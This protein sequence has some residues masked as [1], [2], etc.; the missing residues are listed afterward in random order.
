MFRRLAVFL[1][2]LV[3][4]LYFAALFYK[5]VLY[6]VWPFPG[7]VL[8]S[9]FYPWNSG[10]WD[11]WREGIFHKEVIAS[12][13]F[14]LY[15][16]WK[17][18]G[19]E[20]I[21]SGQLPLWNPYNFSG[22][23]LLANFQSSFFYPF[24][25]FFYF[26]PILPAWIVYIFWQPIIGFV[27][28]YLYLR[29]ITKEKTSALVGALGFISTGFMLT[30]FDWGIVGHAASWLGWML[31]VFEKT[32]WQDTKKFKLIA[33]LVVALT[34]LSGYPQI[35]LL[36]F[37]ITLFY[38]IY[39]IYKSRGKR[40]AKFFSFAGLIV[41]GLAIASFQL[42]PSLEFALNSA[43]EVGRD[44]IFSKFAL[45]WQSLI[46]IFAPDFFGNIATSNFWGSFHYQEHLSYFGVTLLPLSLLALFRFKSDARVRLFAYV[47]LFSIALVLPTPLI[48]ILKVVPVMSSGIPTRT[49]FLFQSSMVILAALGLDQLL[50]GKIK[51]VY[52]F[53]TATAVFI[54]YAALWG[55][56]YALGN[57]FPVPLSAEDLSVTQRNLILPSSIAALSILTIV[58]FRQ[59]WIKT[60]GV[61]GVY[62][63]LI[64]VEAG[65]FFNKFS[66]FASKN[67]FFPSHPLFSDL[68]Q[69][70]SIQRAWGYGSGYVIPNFE[71][72]YKYQS[73]DGYDPLYIKRYGELLS[74]INSGKLEPSEK[75]A[76]ANLPQEYSPNLIKIA[77]L[78]GVSY[79][80]FNFN[81]QQKHDDPMWS[82]FLENA[83]PIR[84]DFWPISQDIEAYPRAFLVGEY[85]TATTDEKII[86]RMFDP[87]V[88][89]AKEVVLEKNI[90]K[91]LDP[92]VG[93]TEI[94]D[95]QPNAVRIKTNSRGDNLLFLS[96]NY[97]PGWNAYVD[98][99][100]SEI[101]RSDYTFRSVFIPKGEHNVV[102]KYEPVSVKIGALITL[103]SLIAYMG[104]V[105]EKFWRS[106]KKTKNR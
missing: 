9:Y 63:I 50:T 74:S 28:M 70:A 85:L 38:T 18:L 58:L 73:T 42:V 44:A 3:L 57:F 65:Y 7:D 64:I 43:R 39:P 32:F 66:P 25:I 5:V 59:K 60:W 21:R 95:Y 16:P 102:F 27:G 22:T 26:L 12:D 100:K 94:A 19:A 96:D 33:P 69:I 29:A 36:I 88:N 56:V 61:L 55:T 6:N 103:T 89:L 10:G 83:K 101:Y 84:S 72:Y 48:N 99:T 41:F 49:L 93:S 8:V 35:A 24:G 15:I 76:D 104:W 51:K 78:M 97:Y 80:S 30:W 105:S 2:V 53:S 82:Q 75:R 106:R 92:F 20:L 62:V 37:T 40:L 71:T 54:V 86:E 98:G 47:S 14:R 46:T 17:S 23:P 13:V 34:V 79:Y 90:G 87:R 68:S 45:P 4:F 1:P 52:V 67:Y 31:W 91:T 11:G 77:R 81:K